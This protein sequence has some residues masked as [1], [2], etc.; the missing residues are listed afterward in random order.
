MSDPS[1]MIPPKI[2]TQQADILTGWDA[3]WGWL[4]PGYELRRIA[5]KVGRRFGVSTAD[6][7]VRFARL[8]K[9]YKVVEDGD[10]S[11]TYVAV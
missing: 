6:V 3:F 1:P 2:L 8:G 7:E 10:G 11:P 4:A 9:T 5:A